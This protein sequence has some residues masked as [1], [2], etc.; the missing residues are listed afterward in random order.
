MSD[1]DQQIEHMTKKP[2]IPIEGF[3]YITSASFKNSDI[4]IP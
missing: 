3:Y 1:A 2:S 4:S